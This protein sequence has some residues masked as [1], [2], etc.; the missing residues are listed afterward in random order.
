MTTLSNAKKLS[1]IAAGAICLSLGA[2]NPAQAQLPSLVL[3]AVGPAKS[4]PTPA[5][6]PGLIGLGLGVLRK[7][8]AAAGAGETES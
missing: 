1:I 3:V 8:K 7:R 5:L 2:M 6:L 4:I